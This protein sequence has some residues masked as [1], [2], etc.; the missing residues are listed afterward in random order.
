MNDARALTHTQVEEML[1]AYTAR[2]LTPTEQSGMEQ[3]LAECARCRLALTE[4]QQIRTLMGLLAHEAEES[5]VHLSPKSEISPLFRAT[6]VEGADSK[7]ESH[8]PHV[9]GKVIPMQSLPSPA[10]SP[11][12]RRHTPV[13]AIVAA[14]LIALLAASV[15]AVEQHA[16]PGLGNHRQSAAV[17]TVPSVQPGNTALVTPAP[18]TMTPI[19]FVTS[20]AAIYS[21][22]EATQAVF[23]APT[24]VFKVGATEIIVAETNATVRTGDVLSIRWMVNGVD[25]TTDF[26]KAQPS[27]CSYRVPAGGNAGVVVSFHFTSVQPGPVR[28]ELSYNGTLA[29]T[30]VANFVK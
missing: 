22:P 2:E 8:V 25:V 9:Q 26:Q 17:T 23:P 4:V 28:A 18:N 14:T 24:S 21:L 1:A 15:F 12:R 6:G 3:H 10:D 20:V 13:S 16:R 30:I 7:S 29:Y 5:H 27:C 19:I 11:A